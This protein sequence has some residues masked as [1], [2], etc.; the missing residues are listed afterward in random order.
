MA[1]TAETATPAR[2]ELTPAQRR[3]LDRLRSH[4]RLPEFPGLGENLRDHLEA[5]LGPLGERWRA[6]T[7]RERWTITKA[8]LDLACERRFVAQQAEPF[9]WSI[10]KALGTFAGAMFGL[11][12]FAPHETDGVLWAQAVDQMRRDQKSIGAWVERLSAGEYVEMRQTACSWHRQFVE[13]FPPLPAAWSPAVE[14]SYYVPLDRGR[15]ALR[16]R[17]DVQIGR[18]Q[19]DLAGTVIIDVKSHAHATQLE[20]VSLYAL[21]RAMK[22]GTPPRKVGVFGLD[23]GALLIE[24]VTEDRLWATA[25][26]VVDRATRIVELAEG[27][28]PGVQAS[29]ICGWCPALGRC[30]EGQAQVRWRSGLDEGE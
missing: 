28:V 9:S 13:T 30:V 21:L 5:A 22:V 2:V 26:T 23:D 6:A 10:E 1:D 16:G 17:A 25:A 29:G 8:S 12:V 7:G 20:E 14:V 24:D 19:G 3:N 11:W 15:V 18:D 4:G 27:R